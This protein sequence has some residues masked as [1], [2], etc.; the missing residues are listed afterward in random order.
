MALTT[1]WMLKTGRLLDRDPILHELT[2]EELIEFW[3]D[4]LYEC[5]INQETKTQ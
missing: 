2:A 5:A 3:S 1:V 4:D